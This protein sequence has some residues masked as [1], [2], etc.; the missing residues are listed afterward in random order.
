[1]LYT[2]GSTLSMRTTVANETCPEDLHDPE[3]SE[4]F[5]YRKVS[6]TL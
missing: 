1:M 3:V 2:R 6:E 4:R 5:S